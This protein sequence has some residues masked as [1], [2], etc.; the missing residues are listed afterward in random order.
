METIYYIK[1]NNEELKQNMAIRDY[2][3][4]HRLDFQTQLCRTDIFKKSVNNFGTKL[5][6]INKTS[7]LFKEFG[8][9]KTF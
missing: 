8:E 7:K 2:K 4:R 1:L 3:T 9:F 6:K 5:N